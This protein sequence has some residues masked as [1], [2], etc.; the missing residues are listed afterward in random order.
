MKS[1]CDHGHVRC[2][3]CDRRPPSVR[4]AAR[5]EPAACGLDDRCIETGDAARCLSCR[6]AR[7]VEDRNYGGAVA[8]RSGAA[9]LNVRGIGPTTAGSLM[10]LPTEAWR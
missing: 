6:G 2:G 4:R 10:V 5:Q 7:S 1:P 9:A 3:V 8:S